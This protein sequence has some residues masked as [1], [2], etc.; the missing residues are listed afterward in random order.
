MEERKPEEQKSQDEGTQRESFSF[1]QETI[2]PKPVTGGQIAL[3]LS[4]MAVYGLIIGA[5]ACCGFYALRPWAQETFHE[6]AQEVTLPKDEEEEP[7]PVQEEEEEKEPEQIG[8]AS[9]RERV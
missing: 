4:K 3:Q 8:R 1:L 6:E 9:C 5:A 2:K 7:E